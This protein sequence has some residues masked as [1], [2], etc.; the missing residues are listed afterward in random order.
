MIYTCSLD[1]PLGVV[2]A[3]A[4]DGAVTG[5]W[6]AG[7][8]HYPDPAG[9]VPEPDYPV[10][11]VLGVWLAEYFAGAKPQ[12]EFKLT[13][14]GTSFQKKVWELLVDIPYGEV[15]TYGGIARQLA[16]RSG[17]PSAS[18]RAV[19]GAVGHNPISI[20]IPCHR[21]VGSTGNLTGYAGGLERKK[22]LLRLEG[23][24]V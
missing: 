3:S 6:F 17:T 16:L 5:L 12:P 22:A 23:K 9:W 8:K 10:F 14:R 13:P 2:T 7:Q 11:K 1:T 4:E 20:L 24:E 19:G 15:S 18:A 21:V